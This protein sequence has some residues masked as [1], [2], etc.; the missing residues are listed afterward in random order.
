M[1]VR[2]STAQQVIEG[3]GVGVVE[4]DA[5]GFGLTYDFAG[6]EHV[7]LAG[8]P[9]RGAFSAALVQVQIAGVDAEAVEQVSPELLV[10]TRL[11]RGPVFCF[12][13]LNVVK[14]PEFEL[15]EI[16]ANGSAV[17]NGPDPFLVD[18]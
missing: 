2:D 13:L 16:V 10:V 1:R 9:R 6:H 8:T 17:K 5:E 3:L 4:R 14:P 15:G 7:N 18:T 11:G 12:P